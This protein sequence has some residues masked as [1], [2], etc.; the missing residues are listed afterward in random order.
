MKH[1]LKL[2]LT[3][4][5]SQLLV[6][7]ALDETYRIQKSNVLVVLHWS[8]RITGMSVCMSDLKTMLYSFQ[9]QVSYLTLGKSQFVLYCV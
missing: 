5:Q 6:C 7:Q 9:V 1:S 4:K 3:V 8:R 2:A